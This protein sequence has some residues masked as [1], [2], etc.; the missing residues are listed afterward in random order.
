MIIINFKL[1]RLILLLAALNFLVYHT[2]RSPSTHHEIK[3]V[4]DKALDHFASQF[5]S[6]IRS[7]SEDP[8]KLFEIQSF[9]SCLIRRAEWRSTISGPKLVM[10]T[11]CPSARN[12]SLTHDI[13]RL[14]PGKRLLLVGPETTHFLH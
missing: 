13:C 4:M 2:R 5:L 6:K 9:L 12:V 3:A 7:D 8:T 14:L 10:P 11:T 1:V